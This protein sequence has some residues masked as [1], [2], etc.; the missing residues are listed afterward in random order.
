MSS[1]PQSLP[2]R[3]SALLTSESASIS[4]HHCLKCDRSIPSV[5][6]CKGRNV[7]NSCRHKQRKTPKKRNAVNE[8]RYGLVYRQKYPWRTLLMHARKRASKLGLKYDLDQHIP[9]MQRRIMAM[10]CEM[11]GV[12]LIPGSGC[13]SQGK[14][15][16]NTVSLDRKDSSQGYTINNVRIVCWAMN[17]AMGTWG[18]DILRSI[19]ASWMKKKECV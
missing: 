1:V 17:A 5:S 10:K 7:C 18:E 2:Q 6:F 15:Y 4:S 16:W 14:R 11:T 19:V 9:E 13:G 12:T 8:Q 3:A